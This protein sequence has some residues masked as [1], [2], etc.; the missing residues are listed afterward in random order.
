MNLNEL[1]SLKNEYMKKAEK[2]E[3][4][5]KLSILLLVTMI[6]LT[7]LSSFIVSPAAVPFFAGLSVI[8]GIGSFVINLKRIKNSADIS[9]IEGKIYTWELNLSPTPSP[10]RDNVLENDKKNNNRFSNELSTEPKNEKV[11]V[12]TKKMKR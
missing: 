8:S 2:L 4:L 12:L 5:S 11:K 6:P 7:V 9:H 1:L 10:F 3:G